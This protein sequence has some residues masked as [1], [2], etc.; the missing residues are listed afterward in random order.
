MIGKSRIEIKKGT[1]PVCNSGGCHVEACIRTGKIIK[2]TGDPESLVGKFY[3]RAS[4]AVDYRYHPNRCNYPPKRIGERG[5]R[6]W[7][8]IGWE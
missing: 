7:E 3:E 8:R 4:V 1:C 6:K 2:I 5:D